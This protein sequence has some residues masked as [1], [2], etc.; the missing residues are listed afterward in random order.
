MSDLK[1]VGVTGVFTL[2]EAPVE[3]HKHLEGGRVYLPVADK[4]PAVREEGG[5][6]TGDK[7]TNR[8]TAV[9]RET[10]PK[11]DRTVSDLLEPLKEDGDP[12]DSGRVSVSISTTIFRMEGA[13]RPPHLLE[14]EN[15]WGLWL[16]LVPMIILLIAGIFQEPLG[17]LW[18]DLLSQ[19]I[20]KKDFLVI[21]LS[22]EQETSPLEWWEDPNRCR[23]IAQEAF[24]DKAL[25]SFRIQITEGSE[26]ICGGKPVDPDEEANIIDLG[27]RK[28][29]DCIP[30]EILGTTE[31][32]QKD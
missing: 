21:D 27:D 5:E 9:G 15:G 29:Y 11:E 3:V 28:F 7:K 24:F 14:P 16:M 2:I 31:E 6:L 17:R 32:T 30:S 26:C 8:S 13:E 1:Q 23:G 20:T 4:I 10:F 25:A 12:V 22:E 19:S 18:E